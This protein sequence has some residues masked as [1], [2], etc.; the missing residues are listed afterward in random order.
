MGKIRS[1]AGESL[2]LVAVGAGRLARR[3]PGL[4][5][6]PIS[7]A[8]AAAGLYDHSYGYIISALIAGAVGVGWYV[9]PLR[10]IEA[11]RRA[12][13]GGTGLT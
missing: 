12:G 5:A 11:R 4:L 13:A 2:V 1:S 10:G 6:I 9:S 7:Y 8:A 3:W